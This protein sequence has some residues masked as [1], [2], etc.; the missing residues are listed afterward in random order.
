VLGHV[1]HEQERIQ[2]GRLGLL[3][4]AAGEE[5]PARDFAF[6]VDLLVRGLGTLA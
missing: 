2:L 1:A 6:G 3:P 5:E 4:V